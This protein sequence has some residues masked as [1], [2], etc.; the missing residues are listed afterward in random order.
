M[1]VVCWYTT[2]DR[3]ERFALRHAPST[4]VPSIAAQPRRAA[5]KQNFFIGTY[6]S[7]KG[8]MS[9]PSLFL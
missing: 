6:L 4:S 7:K 8:V 3:A 9:R 5:I 1:V 2:W